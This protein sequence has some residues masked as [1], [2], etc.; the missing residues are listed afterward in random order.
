MS[1]T[2]YINMDVINPTK[3][4]FSNPMTSKEKEDPSLMERGMSNLEK[5]V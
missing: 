3:M 5:E 4:D 2:S 1:G